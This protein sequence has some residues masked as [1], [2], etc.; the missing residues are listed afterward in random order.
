MQVH[1]NEG[2]AIRIG[3]KPCG[4]IREGAAEASAEVRVGQPL[5]HDMV[6]VPGADTLQYV[7]GNILCRVIASDTGARRGRRTWHACTLLVREPGDLQPDRRAHSGS[8]AR[9]GKARSRSR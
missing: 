3:L 1:C 5:S 4:G 6:F 7:E 9:V 8:A 2:V